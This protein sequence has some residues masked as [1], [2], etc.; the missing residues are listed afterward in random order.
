MTSIKTLPGSQ[1]AFIVST[2]S[3]VNLVVQMASTL[4]ISML[5]VKLLPTQDASRW[6]LFS[7]SLPF[8]MIFDLGVGNYL[9]KELPVLSSTQRSRK[10][11]S[12]VVRSHLSL[13]FLIATILLL[14]M[15]LIHSLAGE[16]LP[17]LDRSFL[18]FA[19]GTFSR[20]LMNATLSS[21]YGFGESL[22]DRC[23]RVLANLAFLVISVSLVHYFPTIEA[24]CWA[25]LLANVLILTL[26][27]F[28]L[29]SKLGSS[30]ISA[31]INKTVLKRSAHYLLQ[32]TLTSI[33]VLFIYNFTIFIVTRYH[34]PHAVIELGI[35]N[36]IA[37]GILAITFIPN[38]LLNQTLSKNFSIR[39]EAVDHELALASR[40]A[41]VLGG[42]LCGFWF[43]NSD[44]IFNLWNLKIPHLVLIPFII[45]L[46]FEVPQVS[47]TSSTYATGYVNFWK[48][49]LSAGVLITALGFTLIP[50]YGVVGAGIALLIGQVLTCEIFNVKIALKI[51]K[52]KWSFYAS[53]VMRFIAIMILFG[54]ANIGVHFATSNLIVLIVLNSILALGVLWADLRRVDA[55]LKL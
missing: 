35:I 17:S 25:W 6:I 3:L 2:A 27:V 5:V 36:Q 4:M 38:F 1:N 52:K 9:M 19:T 54:V 46:I 30:V 33:P 23:G 18:I 26:S 34:G 41:V 16:S 21:L 10:L 15:F 8:I 47:L 12:T 53:R 24:I 32:W 51:F 55:L 37:Q 29:Q 14:S 28:F 13:L 43:A 31:K 7:A 20:V 44:I 42:S 49:A 39:P 11:I 50:Q 40:I 22:L 48:I 45:F